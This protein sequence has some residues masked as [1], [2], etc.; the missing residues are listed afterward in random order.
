MRLLGLGRKINANVVVAQHLLMCF[1]VFYPR[2]RGNSH[3][4]ISFN[5]Y[6]P[7]LIGIVGCKEREIGIRCILLKGF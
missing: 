7:K 6:L 5:V 1:Q 4:V 2:D 3:I